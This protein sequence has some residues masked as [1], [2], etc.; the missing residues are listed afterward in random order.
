MT[1]SREQV[2]GVLGRIDDLKLAQILG[3]KPTLVQLTEAK[4][5]LAGQETMAQ[6]LGRSTDP[7]AIQVLDILKAD[8]AEE[9]D[10]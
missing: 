2:I 9:W 10:D 4:L 6:M 3:A 8:E 1:L 7:V 5:M